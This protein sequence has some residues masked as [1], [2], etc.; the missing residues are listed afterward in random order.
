MLVVP[1]LRTCFA[2]F[3]KSL[4]QIAKLKRAGRLQRGGED[5]SPSGAHL[6]QSYS[7]LGKHFQSSIVDRAPSVWR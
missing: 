6:K 1:L 5:E 4:Q 2:H 7:T 3:V